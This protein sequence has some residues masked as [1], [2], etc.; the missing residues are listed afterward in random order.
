[1]RKKIL[2]VNTTFRQEGPNEVMWQLAKYV[3][4]SRFELVFA[5]MWDGGPME[6]KYSEADCGTHNLNMNRFTDLGAV[7]R[8]RDFVKSERFDLVTAQLLRAEVFGG[9]GTRLAKVPLVFVVQ[10]MDPYRA[11][12]VLFPHYYLSR[13]SMRWPIRIV[14]VSEHVRQFIMRYQKVEDE[15]IRVI[16]NAVDSELFLK[17]RGERQKVRD[18][19]D[20]R[21]E[22]TVIGS[23]SRFA[24]QKGLFYLLEAF[25]LLRSRHNGIRLI[26]VGDGPQRH[27]IENWIKK[28]DL[29]TAILLPGFPHDFARTMQCFDILAI[30]SLWEGMPLVLLGGMASGKPVV[31]T[32]V[33]GIP[34]VVEN[35]VNGLLVAPKSAKELASGIDKLIR[36][37]QFRDQLG[38]NAS[39]YVKRN[40][41]PLDLV[42]RYEK[43]WGECLD[44]R[45]Q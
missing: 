26:L 31:S 45:R 18:E 4:R 22:E 42:K 32:S 10:N 44:G 21:P 20:L 28:H 34:E 33:S 19:F 3:D 30:S 16:Q 5:C 39:D 7:L 40:C 8:V 1:M 6:K 41:S 43:L 12:P 24:A 38:Q 27:K 2:I 14:A 17:W 11:N 23:V 36:D 35:G 29:Q 37:P 13:I 9:L 25:K 15:R